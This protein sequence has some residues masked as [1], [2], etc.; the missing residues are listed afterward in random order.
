MP[1]A[2]KAPK[3]T[4]VKSIHTDLV[5]HVSAGDLLIELFDYEE[6]KILSQ[7]DRA[8][9]ENAIKKI[10]AQGA[11][12]IDKI[13]ALAEIVDLRLVAVTASQIAYAWISDMLK[14]GEKTPLDLT[15]ARQEMALRSY[16]VLQSGVEHEI[17]SRNAVDSISIFDQ[18]AILLQ[19]EREYVERSASRLRI[20]APRAGQFTCYVTAGTPV[21][22][23]HLL[24]EIN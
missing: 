15:F 16:Q 10:E 5:A 24:G 2:I 12:V 22:L 23:G 13:K 9:E 11:F 21:R 1:I 3:A 14:A 6:Q 7:I 17:F 19:K 18:V 8:I 20:A 4:Q